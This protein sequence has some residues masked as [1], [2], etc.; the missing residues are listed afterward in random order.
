MGFI[1]VIGVGSISFNG[2]RLAFTPRYH[3]FAPSSAYVI[4]PSA[5]TDGAASSS[6][7]PSPPPRGRSSNPPTSTSPPATRAK[8]GHPGNG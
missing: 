1:Y 8:P 7:A 3:I 2:L 4:C 6:L 5:M